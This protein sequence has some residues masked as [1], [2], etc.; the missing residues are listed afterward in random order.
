MIF[1][2]GNH[3]NAKIMDFDNN[4]FWYINYRHETVALKVNH[5][6]FINTDS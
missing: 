5:H 3:A 4:G 1:V 6:V 2:K